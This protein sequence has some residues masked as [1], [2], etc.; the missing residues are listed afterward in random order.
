MINKLQNIKE[1]KRNCTIKYQHMPNVIH[2]QMIS[3]VFLAHVQNNVSAFVFG[4]CKSIMEQN[5]IL[6]L[7]AI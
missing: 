5:L 3:P 7:I 6:K 1:T 2:L 4:N